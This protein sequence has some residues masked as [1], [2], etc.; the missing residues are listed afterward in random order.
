MESV[1]REWWAWLQRGL[2]LG[3]QLG[4]LLLPQGISFGGFGGLHGTD[5]GR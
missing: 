3:N 2:L 4:V 5:S 1:F